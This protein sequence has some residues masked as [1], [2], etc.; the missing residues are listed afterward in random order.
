MIIIIIVITIILPQIQYI[1]SNN[2]ISIP[3]Y[4]NN[5]KLLQYIQK[6]QFQLANDEI[7][8]SLDNQTKWKNY[9]ILDNKYQ[10]DFIFYSKNF[11]MVVL[12][13]EGSSLSNIKTKQLVYY[14]IFKSGNDNIRAHLYRSAIILETGRLLQPGFEHSCCIADETK[15]GKLS[16]SLDRCHHQ[17]IQ[18]I[19]PGG[20]M[21]QFLNLK[22]SRYPFT[23]VRDP[24][25][26]FV[27]GYAEIEYRLSVK[28]NFVHFLPIFS[29]VGTVERFKE[30]IRMI[31]NSKGS[32]TLFRDSNTEL[33]HIAPQI[34]AINVARR[35]EKIKINIYRLE[36]FQE[37]W[38]RLS[39]ETDIP[40]LLHALHDNQLLLHHSSKDPNKT[41]EAAYRLL[42][43]ALLLNI[44]D[45][46]STCN[47]ELSNDT[48]EIFNNISY[49]YLRALCRIYLP[50]F[51]CLGYELPQVCYTILDDVQVSIN[52]YNEIQ[53][54]LKKKASNTLQQYIPNYI[55]EYISTSICYILLATTPE[56]YYRTI[57]WLQGNEYNDNDDE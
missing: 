36:K 40:E 42:N 51:T 3:D 57:T 4:C 6:E 52:H 20:I 7:L 12:D 47:D 43:P 35:T 27:S 56:C 21:K 2:T 13:L 44:T 37:E 17:Y 8:L 54:I 25:A 26:R 15:P 46:Y 32:N 18:M 9:T 45:R 10:D 16:C 11:G 19:P 50:D 23:F 53:D 31:V 48:N 24:I 14:R 22:T 55:L 39:K 28:K 33:E 41:K 34:G 49:H 38:K 30:F 5:E 1:T 29:R